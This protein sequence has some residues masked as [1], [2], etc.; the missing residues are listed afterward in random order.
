MLVS[1]EKSYWI[2]SVEDLLR[3]LELWTWVLLHDMSPAMLDS[4]QRTFCICSERFLL[5]SENEEFIQ[6]S[7]HCKETQQASFQKKNL[8]IRVKDWGFYKGLRTLGSESISGTV[9]LVTW[10]LLGFGNICTASQ[11][12]IS[13]KPL[14]FRLGDLHTWEECM[15]LVCILSYIYVFSQC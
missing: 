3:D 10:F 15:A 11:V 13:K 8:V 6:I 2:P 5:G 1:G 14:Q 4:T 12:Q 9:F 7:V